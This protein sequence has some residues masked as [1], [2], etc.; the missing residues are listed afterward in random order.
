MTWVRC[1]PTKYPRGPSNQRVQ[2]SGITRRQLDI[3]RLDDRDGERERR[4]RAE[5]LES[6]IAHWALNKEMPGNKRLR[7]RVPRGTTQPRRCL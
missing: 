3:T 7:S 6:G 5:K 2:D 1:S 4:R